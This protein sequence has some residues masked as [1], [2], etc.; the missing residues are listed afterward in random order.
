MFRRIRGSVFE[1]R[2]QI[3]KAIEDYSAAMKT[4][5]THYDYAKRGSLYVKT[6]DLENAL[7]D[8][9]EAIKLKPDDEDHYTKRAEIYRKLGKTVPAGLVKP[10]HTDTA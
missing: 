8:Y 2:N 10:T 7:K 5:A 6:N 1:K 4:D 9:T 3:D